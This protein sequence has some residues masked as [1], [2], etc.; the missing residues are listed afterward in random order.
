M[1]NKSQMS[2]TKNKFYDLGEEGILK[3][4]HSVLAKGEPQNMIYM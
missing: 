1:G 2:D 3:E 4:V